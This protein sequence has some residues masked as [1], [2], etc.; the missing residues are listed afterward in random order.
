MSS[1][2]ERSGGDE[3][4]SMRSLRRGLWL[5]AAL[6]AVGSLPFAYA[7][8]TTPDDRVYTGLMFDVPDH[9][10]YWSWV[11]ASRRS[12]FIPNT[13]TPEP[14]DAVFFNPMMWLLAQI[15]ETW[16]LSF[17]ALM[18]VWRAMAAALL[19]VAVVAGTGAFVTNADRR[20]SAAW[21]ALAGAGFGWVLVV[22]K[23][24][25]GLDDLPFPQDVYTVEPNTFFASFAYP[26]LAMAQGLVLLVMVGAWQAHRGAGGI[27][28]AVGA[29]VLLALSHAYDLI[30]VYGVLGA[31]WLREAVRLRT[32][33]AR[34]TVVSVLIGLC[35]APIALY[36]RSLTASDPLWQSIL[37]QYANA[38]VWTPRHLHLVVLMGVPL[39][40]AAAAW[41]AAWR[42]DDERGFLATWAIAGLGLIYLPAVFQI[43][44][45]TGWQFPLAMLAAHAWHGKVMPFLAGWLGWPSRGGG[46]Q[47]WAARAI[48]VALV[49]P[50][51]LYLFAWRFVDLRRHETPYFLHRDEMAAF[52]WLS[53]TTRPS[54]VVLAPIE[55]GQ[56]VP[57]YGRTRAYLAHWAMT[58]RFFERRAAVDRFFDPATPDAQRARILE[59]DRV[60]L[61][62]RG[63]TRRGN[64]NYDPAAS[65]LFEPVFVRPEAAVFRYRGLSVRDGRRAR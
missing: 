21:I 53:A 27:A 20:R 26:Y 30:T 8:A 57:N 60:T 11:T 2:I 10:Q 65:P 37:A 38:G 51:N 13:M 18:Q 32:V 14:N 41:P 48:L 36:Y 12:L 44:L 35:S 6:F 61:V 1:E 17:A 25:L 40:L 9:A 3:R 16:G 24:S 15:Q 42:A 56:F 64:P 49:M 31:F 54:D 52:E 29:S 59:Q 19:G 23:R 47:G 46:R 50:T 43:K 62:L 63:S 5:G 4:F 39:L 58:N 22:V 28:L 7:W 45:L 33:P 34:L 55:L